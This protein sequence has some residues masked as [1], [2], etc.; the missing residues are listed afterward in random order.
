VGDGLAGVAV[1]SG[2]AQ[3]PLICA[4]NSQHAFTV[5][6][7]SGSRPRGLHSAFASLNPH[8]DALRRTTE[9]IN[10]T[11]QQPLVSDLPA[12][13][14][15]YRYDEPTAPIHLLELPLSRLLSTSCTRE[16]NKLEA[17]GILDGKIW[18]SRR[19]EHTGTSEAIGHT[20]RKPEPSL[21]YRME[22]GVIWGETNSFAAGCKGS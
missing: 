7:L 1:P 5:Y 3:R 15:L 21:G 19:G 13:V 11:D 4:N 20:P 6:Q 12:Q 9:T 17:A 18:L 8:V 14:H 16:V 22:S 2:L 10:I